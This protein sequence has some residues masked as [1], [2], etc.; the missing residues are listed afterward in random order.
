MKPIREGTPG[1]TTIFLFGPQLIKSVSLLLILLYSSLNAQQILRKGNAEY[2]SNILIV[3]VKN[4]FTGNAASLAKS[5]AKY[6]VADAVQLFP[7]TSRLNKGEAVLSR[8]YRARL[9]GGDPVEMAKKVSKQ[10]DVEWAEPKYVHRIT[11]TPNDSIYAKKEQ[12]NLARIFADSAWNITK[13]DKKTI[14]GI[15]DTGVDWLHPDLQANIL[16]DSNGKMVGFDLGGLNGT[17]DNDPSEDIVPNGEYHGTHVAGIADAVTDNT[18]GVASIGYGCSLLPVK[19]SRSD[20]RDPKTGAPYIYYGFEGIQLAVDNGAKVINC[21]WG[22]YTY[23]MFE[24]AIIDY[25][26]SKGTLVVASAGNDGKRDPFYPASYKGVLSVGWLFSTDDVLFPVANYG[27]SIKV[28]APGTYIISTWQEHTASGLLYNTISGSSMSAPL[29]SGLAGLVFSVFPNYSPLQ[30]AEQIR[31]TSDNI[32]ALNADSLKHLLGG[33][34]INAYRAVTKT[35][36]VSVRADSVSFIDEGNKNGLLE[37]GEEASIFVNFTNYLS[38]VQNLSVQLITADN[39]VQLENSSFGVS[40]LNTLGTIS[41]TANMFKFKINQNS[42][43]N[44]DVYFQLI[45]STPGGYSDFQWIK[46]R[47]NPSYATHDNNNIILSV[48]SKGTLGFDDFP[49]NLEGEGFKYKSGTN[50]MFEGA[51]MYGTGPTKVMNEARDLVD[52]T[53]DF[54][55]ISPIKITQTNSTQQGY[56]VFSDSGAGSNALG[57]E[58]RLSTLSYSQSPNDNFVILSHVLFNKTNQGINGLYAGY[59]IDWDI[60]AE[61]YDQDTTYFDPVDKFAVSYNVKDNTTAYTGVALL[62]N[63]GY[64]YYGIDNEA[65]SGDVIIGDANGF[66]DSEKWLT[67]S[68]GVKKNSAGVGDISLVVSGGPYN[69]PARNSITV[70]FAVAGGATLDDLKKAIRQCRNIYV[71]VNDLPG[72]NIPVEY[73]LFQ[74]YPNPFNPST[75]IKYSIPAR[76][77]TRSGGRRIVSDEQSEYGIS[78][79]KVYDILGREVATLVNEEKSPGNYEVKFDAAKLPSGVYFYTLRAGDFVQTKKMVVLK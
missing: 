6:S 52:Q 43:I 47:I 79:L 37:S 19:A 18:I 45:F 57:I 23:S 66:S 7:Q 72:Q 76:E 67:L 3:K 77:T 5:L 42:P 61:G 14:I 71:A 21:S 50:L 27:P 46:V 1:R 62:S 75:T 54:I 40:A 13:G 26:V 41:N 28:C 48:S 9:S 74:N 30:V 70:A 36:A 38:P 63:I 10:S 8:I 33:G 49:E 51:F 31:V 58:T 15:V 44:H 11:Y 17:P 78:T 60:P 68:N 4:S 25:A 24:Q 32:D 39:S 35:D 53:A 2:I 16:K 64:G 56:T 34:R 59:Y 20:M 22:D 73:K 69:I 65:T 29:V 12:L 55:T